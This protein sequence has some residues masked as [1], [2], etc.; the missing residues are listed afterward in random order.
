MQVEPDPRIEQL[1]ERLASDAQQQE[2]LAAKLDDVERRLPSDVVSPADLLQAL[3]QA[4]TRSW[5]K[6]GWS[7]IRGSR[8]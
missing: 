5:R 8:C 7:R 2:S 3:A 4:R 1:A 6:R